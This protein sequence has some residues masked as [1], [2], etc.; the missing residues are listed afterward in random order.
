M[1]SSIFW[2]MT[3]WRYIQEYRIVIRGILQ[4]LQEK[5]LIMP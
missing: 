2:D 4:S 5:Y 1:K 3:T